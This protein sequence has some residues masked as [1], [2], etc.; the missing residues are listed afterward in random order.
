MSFIAVD[1][2]GESSPSRLQAQI[3]RL[4]Q[5]ACH[6]GSWVALHIGKLVGAEAMRRD[7]RNRENKQHGW[8]GIFSNLGT[9]NV[10]DSGSWIFCPAIARS[11]PVGAGCVTLN[12]R[13]SLTLQLHDGF[14]ENLQT[15][16]TL[17][18]AW[19]AACLNAPVHEQAEGFEL[20]RVLV[21]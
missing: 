11:Y 2:L 9:W 20:G 4:K 18:E 14:G 1:V 19:T 6:W 5:R 15:S 16:R 7:I 12:G 3:T 10:P 21:S 17:L 8:T 13:M